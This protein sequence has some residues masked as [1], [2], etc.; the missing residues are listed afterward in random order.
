MKICPI[1]DTHH[2]HTLLKLPP[3][4]EVDTII[5][6]GDFSTNFAKTFYS[7]LDWYSDL[8]YKNKIL[9]AGNH[10]EYIFGVGYQ[11]IYEK[12]KAV[13]VIYLQDSSVEIDGIK[14]HGSPWSNSFGSWVFMGDE[15]ALN[16]HWSLIPDDTDV[17]ITHGPA[18]G[19]GDLVNNSWSSDNHVGSKTLLKK[20]DE[21]KSLKLH[22][23]GHIH[24]DFGE[25]RAENQ[26]F[27]SY[28]A[29]SFDYYKAE[30]NEPLVFE[31]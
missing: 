27:I 26:S 30:L 6:A 20:L 3:S 15:D 29:S 11:N 23:Y 8:P 5:H 13:G 25:H 2:K 1:S 9:V 4:D 17:L 24:E 12:C 22:L 28:N 19:K 31:I 7:F 10:D 16:G 18:Y 21:L 14:F